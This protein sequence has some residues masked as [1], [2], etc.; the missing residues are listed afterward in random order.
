M[1][2]ELYYRQEQRIRSRE[3][4]FPLIWHTVNVIV[5]QRDTQNTEPYMQDVLY[6]VDVIEVRLQQK[7]INPVLQL[8]LEIFMDIQ[9]LLRIWDLNNKAVDVMKVD[10]GVYVII[11]EMININAMV[12]IY[13]L[14]Q[15]RHVVV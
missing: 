9:K 8:K 4:K 10:I 3:Q 13:N 15:L 14:V 12:I 1:E 2:N 7:E 5:E 11:V 6:L